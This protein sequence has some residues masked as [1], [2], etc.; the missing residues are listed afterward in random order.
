MSGGGRWTKKRETQP[1][2]SSR[3]D[4]GER[5]VGTHLL[6]NSVKSGSCLY[7]SIGKK[8]K[9]IFKPLAGLVINSTISAYIRQPA[10]VRQNNCQVEKDEA[11][12]LLAQ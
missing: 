3:I 8:K 6:F 9:C 10:C 11:E 2:R 4:R 5:A 12:I 7:F 1:A